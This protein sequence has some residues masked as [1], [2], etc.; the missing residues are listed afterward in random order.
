MKFYQ[1]LQVETSSLFLAL[2]CLSVIIKSKT[3]I[4]QVIPITYTPEK[5][6]VAAVAFKG[7]SV[8]SFTREYRKNAVDFGLD[9]HSL[10]ISNKYWLCDVDIVFFCLYI[11][12]HVPKGRYICLYKNSKLRRWLH[13]HLFLWQTKNNYSI[14]YNFA[15]PLIQRHG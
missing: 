12:L 3:F 10:Y 7:L 13:F 4:E 15:V 6:F 8:D 11:Y 9:Q 14:S 1:N 2:Q 5:S